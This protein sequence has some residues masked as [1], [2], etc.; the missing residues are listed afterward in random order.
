VNA[1]D[2]G[3]VGRAAHHDAVAAPAA[4]ISALGLRSQAWPGPDVVLARASAAWALAEGRHRV[5]GL[6]LASCAS[7]E[8]S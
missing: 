8:S 1:R 4:P 7:L 6:E 5:G 2:P 3:G